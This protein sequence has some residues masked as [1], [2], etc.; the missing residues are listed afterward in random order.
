MKI[1]FAGSIRGGR[2]DQSLYAD[3]ITELQK[4]GTVLTEHVAD[5]KITS[6]GENSRSSAEIFERDMSWLRECDMVV[7]EVT[8][9]SLGVGY[10]IG[11]AESLGKKVFCLYRDVEGKSLSAMIAGN[12]SIINFVYQNLKDIKI[13]FENSLK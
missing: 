2:A 7:A 5:K 4:Y 3:I 1:Y 11:T 8:T 13:F 9:P 6:Y 10:E 12:T